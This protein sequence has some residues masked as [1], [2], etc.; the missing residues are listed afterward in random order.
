MN[1]LEKKSMTQDQLRWELET[2]KAVIT[3]HLHGLESE[4]TLAD[5]NVGGRPVLDYVREQPFVAAGV[6][7][8]SA[9]L[10]A[11]IA[12]LLLRKPPPPLPLRE[13]FWDAYL[14]DLIDGAAFRVQRGEDPDRAL[15]HAL[16][17]RAPVIYVEP[18]PPARP[19]PSTMRATFDLLMKTTLG[20]GVKLALDRLAG[21]L[22]GEDEIVDAVKHHEHGAYVGDE[23]ALETPA[24]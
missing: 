10:A 23:A 21:E 13:R 11:L 2:R 18:E 12:T 8:G 7:A 22:T 24:M 3:E 1:E 15:R 14:R 9:A 6:V 16:R 17:R 4:M 19:K 20:F 5:V